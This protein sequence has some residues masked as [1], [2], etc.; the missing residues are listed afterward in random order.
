MPVIEVSH[1]TKSY[2]PR[3]AV[4]DVSFTVDEGEIFGL[5]GPNGA[6]K[7]TTAECTIGLR[8]RDGGTVR[9]LGVDPDEDREPVRR[10][11]GVQLQ[12]ARLPERLTVGEAM[13]LYSSF[14]EQ[15]ADSADLLRTLGLADLVD[16]RFCKLS[17]GQQ[18]RLSIALALVGAPKV[19][20]LDELTTG[21]DPAAR[22]ETWDLIDRVRERGV[23]ILLVTHFMPE[24]EHLCDRLA[25]I[26]GGR[27]V[28]QGTPAEIIDGAGGRQQR[29]R[30]R[31]DAGRE[32]AAELL[33]RDLPEVVTIDR[34]GPGGEQL[35]LSGH[36]DVVAAVTGALARAGIVA[37]GLRLEQASLDD[38]F[39]TLTEGAHA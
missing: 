26:A 27:V 16:Q 10:Q 15:P 35:T 11:V 21:L 3:T 29:M 39:L 7:T 38:A 19:A 6:G 30:F 31:V 23:A 25:V 9:V 14:Y 32:V 37:T 5:L 20:V 12:H 22:R 2:G 34:H 1:L 24:A 18:Q 28:A 36:G 4:A 33:L 17:G 8:H 13:R